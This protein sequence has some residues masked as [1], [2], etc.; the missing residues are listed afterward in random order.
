[1]G[2]VHVFSPEG[3]N[4]SVW[5]MGPGRL[6]VCQPMTW[7]PVGGPEQPGDMGKAERLLLIGI[8][9]TLWL[10]ITQRVCILM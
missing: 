7:R 2:T 10:K 1:M 4:A 8:I 6:P 5:T 9:L 3:G